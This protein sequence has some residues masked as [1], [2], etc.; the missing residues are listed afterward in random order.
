MNYTGRITVNINGKNYALKFGM[1]AL[2]HFSETL[3]YDVEET[4]NELT[5]SG[6]P[7]IKAIAK[8]IYSAIFVEAQFKDQVLDLT[9]EDIIDWV[10]TSKPS[11]LT[12]VINTIMS[13]LSTITEISYP[14]NGQE[15]KKK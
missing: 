4:I 7:Q 12:S 2:F 14:E 3:S 13:G 15:I 1:G 8:F 6:F 5:T 9:Y 10:D 11:E